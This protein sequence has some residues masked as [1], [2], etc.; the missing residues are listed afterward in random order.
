VTDQVA[1]TS[2][3][4]RIVDVAPSLRGALIYA[5]DVYLTA[6]DDGEVDSVDAPI[7]AEFFSALTNAPEPGEDVHSKKAI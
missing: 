1:L 3:V 6:A 5:L 7:I 2:I 4:N